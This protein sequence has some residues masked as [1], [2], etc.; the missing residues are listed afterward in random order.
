MLTG[1]CL[2][3]ACRWT[4]DS[5]PLQ[6]TACDCAACRRYGAIWIYGHKGE[7]V[8]V[9]GPIRAFVRS[10]TD[11][12]SL[13]FDTCETCGNLLAWTGLRPKPEGFTRQ[14]VNLRLADDPAAVAA[15][16]LAH[17]EGHANFG[18]RTRRGTVADLWF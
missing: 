1:T 15:I 12:P 2:C 6:A 16:P 17:H 5:E 10:D 7:D 9:T 13:S 14:A 18:H 4:F 8:R 3:G 11:D